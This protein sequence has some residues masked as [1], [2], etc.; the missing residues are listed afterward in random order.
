M[1]YAR[2]IWVPANSRLNSTVTIGPGPPQASKTGRD[3]QMLLYDRTGGQNTLI[4]PPTQEKVRSRGFPYLPRERAAAILVDEFPTDLSLTSEPPFGRES[5]GRGLSAH[6]PLPLAGQTPSRS[7]R[8]AI[9]LRSSRRLT[10]SIHLS[11]RAT[12][13]LTTPRRISALRH[14]LQQGGRLWI[15]WISSNSMGAAL[16]GEDAELTVVDRVPLTSVGIIRRLEGTSTTPAQQFERPIDLVRVIPGPF[17]RVMHTVNGWP[18]SFTRRV[19]RGQ[20]L[21]TTLGARAWHKPRTQAEVGRR[22]IPHQCSR[23]WTTLLPRFA[24]TR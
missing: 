3:I 23:F 6:S 5:R 10:A 7:Y 13:L 22:V 1:Q 21:F 20:I 8:G 2:D 17:D 16:L 12:G 18:A 19:G 4:F 24:R 14:W 9:Y 15:C 11:G